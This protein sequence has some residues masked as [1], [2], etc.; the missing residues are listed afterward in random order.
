M[1]KV[2]LIATSDFFLSDPQEAVSTFTLFG[3]QKVVFETRIVSDPDKLEPID[4]YVSAVVLNLGPLK[5]DEQID[6]WV[7]AISENIKQPIIWTTF[8]DMSLRIRE[9]KTNDLVV[10]CAER[11]DMEDDDYHDDLRN[12]LSDA[13]RRYGQDLSIKFKQAVTANR[14]PIR[15]LSQA[16]LEL[17]PEEAER[18]RGSN[19]L[20]SDRKSDLLQNLAD[21]ESLLI[22]LQEIVP[23]TD[24]DIDEE[25][26]EKLQEWNARFKKAIATNIE[27][28]VEPENLASAAV[29]TAIIL[30]CGALGGMIG[31]PVG[32]GAGSVFG[33]LITGQLKPGAVAK[34]VEDAVARDIASVEPDN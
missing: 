1:F 33:H 17:L 13:L 32:F 16:I 23:Q 18:I 8:C 27:V 19:E 31:G 29:P 14:Q 10:Y 5:T 12:W 26:I 21:L 25:T 30:S 22:S 11:D 3:E 6:G 28:V 2:T 9:R 15:H 24:S 20:A 34:K 7:K 4:P